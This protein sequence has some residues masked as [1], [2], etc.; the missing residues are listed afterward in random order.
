[1]KPSFTIGSA[2]ADTCRPRRRTSYGLGRIKL[3]HLPPVAHPSERSRLFERVQSTGG[4][5]GILCPDRA[6]PADDFRHANAKPE[7]RAIS[8]DPTATAISARPPT[9]A[10]RR[11]FAG[12][13]PA[14][15][16]VR[17]HDLGRV[18]T[19]G[20]GRPGATVIA[21]ITGLPERGRRRVALASASRSSGHQ[22]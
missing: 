3:R 6:E 5:A 14:R 11:V 1:M 18:D 10:N 7:G 4:H 9:L 2:F 17:E 19:G 12:V 22:S 8:P 16:H 15:P 21:G 13:G 20:G